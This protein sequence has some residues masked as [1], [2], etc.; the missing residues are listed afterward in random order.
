MNN[1]PRQGSST[2]D[3]PDVSVRPSVRQD[4]DNL[5]RS[6]FDRIGSFDDKLQV[7]ELKL[8]NFGLTHLPSLSECT[9]IYT[10]T[11]ALAVADPET[12]LSNRLTDFISNEKIEVVRK[13][14]RNPW[15]TRREIQTQTK[16]DQPS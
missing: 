5:V 7:W 11:S 6:L 1:T 12:E 8:L 4:R 2:R 3:P 13:K 9:P 16:L 10:V 15:N 14:T